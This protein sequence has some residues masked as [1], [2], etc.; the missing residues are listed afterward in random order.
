MTEMTMTAKCMTEMTMTAKC[1]TAKSMTA[2]I[3]QQ[4]TD[5]RAKKLKTHK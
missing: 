4:H 1:M 2:N 3:L 5:L